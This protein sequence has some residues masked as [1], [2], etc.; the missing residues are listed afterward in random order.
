MTNEGNADKEGNDSPDHG[1]RQLNVGLL[2]ALAGGFGMATT[3][4]AFPRSA[5]GQFNAASH[6]LAPYGVTVSGDDASGHDNLRFEI[7]ALPTTEYTQVVGARNRQGA[8]VPHWMTSVLG[9]DATA[10]H[11]HPGEIIPCIRTT[12]EQDRLA[13]HELFD[14]DQAGIVPCFTVESEMLDGGHFGTIKATHFHDGA[15]VPCVRT[16]IEGHSLATHEVFD[17]TAGDIVP[18]VRVATQMLDGGALGPVTIAIDPGLETSGVTVIVGG[19]TYRLARGGL[20]P[21]ASPPA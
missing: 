2:A 1:R 9:D 7:A 4:Q 6:I 14:A 8:I 17:T 3:A 15:I 11:F 10:T 19:V 20:V 5:H 12:I 16:T 18:C 21:D 13:T